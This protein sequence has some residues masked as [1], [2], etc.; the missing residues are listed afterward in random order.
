MS[1]FDIGA[2]D[3][4]IVDYSSPDMGLARIAQD[5]GHTSWVY[6]LGDRSED[7]ISRVFDPGNEDSAR[8]LYSRMDSKIGK[9]AGIV[10][11]FEGDPIGYCWAAEDVG[12]RSK[13]VQK[14]KTLA[15]RL[16]GKEP[17]VWIAQINVLP[18]YWNRGIGSLLLRSTVEK[19][20]DTR[21]LS[22]Y[23]FDENTP[24]LG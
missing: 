1:E 11:M 23:V 13:M 3:L 24:T 19:F 20:E 4:T 7:E 9:F 10:C 2:S 22:T 6:R 17:Y 12:N 21:K 8:Q 16:T 5:I 15:G 14:A 18:E